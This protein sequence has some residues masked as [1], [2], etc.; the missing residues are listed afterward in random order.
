MSEPCCP[1]PGQLLGWKGRG[2]AETLVHKWG[3]HVKFTGCPTASTWHTSSQGPPTLS[4]NPRW[5]GMQAAWGQGSGPS[6]PQPIDEPPPNPHS[7][8]PVLPHRRETAAHLG[9]GAREGLAPPPGSPGGL[10][11]L[12]ATEQQ[13]MTATAARGTLFGKHGGRETQASHT[14]SPGS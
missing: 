2:A 8:D 13:G 4:A 9:T 10:L 5:R 3:P 12:T 6:C 1:T 7:W 11:Q 14:C